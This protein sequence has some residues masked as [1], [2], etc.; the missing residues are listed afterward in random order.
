LDDHPLIPSP[1]PPPPPP[2]GYYVLPFLHDGAL[3]A[4][5][6][7]KADRPAGVLRVPAAWVEP[8]ADRDD[9]AAALGQQLRALA[10]W[11]GL[12]DVEVGPAGDLAPAL[13]SALRA[14]LG[15]Q[16]GP[17]WVTAPTSSATAD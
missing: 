1:A 6:D 5:V 14:A 2:H 15:A 9:V 8:D 16:T 13:R 3:A 4:R 12:G 17:T 11:Q 10:D 7:L